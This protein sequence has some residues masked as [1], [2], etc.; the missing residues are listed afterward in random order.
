VYAF[1]K[2]HE[3]VFTCKAQCRVLNISRSAYYAWRVKKMLPPMA[4]KKSVEQQIIDTFGEHKRRYGARRIAKAIQMKGLKL[5]RYKATRVMKA[6]GLKAIQPRSFV[7]KTTNSRHNYKISPNL[8]LD[9]SLP[10]KPNEVWVGDITYIPMAGGRWCYLGVWMDLFSRKII[11]WQLEEHMKEALIVMAVNKAISTRDVSKG[12]IVHSD[13]GG[14]YGGQVFR[15]VINNKALL[16]S[17]SRADNPYDNAFMESCFSRFK[18]ELLQE[19]IFETI[20]D[21]RTE[22]FEYIEMYYNSIRLHS[23]LDYRSPAQHEAHYL[24]KAIFEWHKRGAMLCTEEVFIER[25][26]E[27][28]S[29]KHK[30]SS[31]ALPKELSLIT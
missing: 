5:S 23:S 28:P 31:S 1:I 22:I 15:G 27:P 30:R 2:S 6:F 19:G 16:Q 8:L 4:D 20:E 3:E 13:R 9:R 12:L 26:I 25:G 24:Q 11:G 7:P 14:Q 17:M 18:A 21:A 10:E 29:I